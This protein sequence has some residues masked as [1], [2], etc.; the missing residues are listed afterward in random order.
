MSSSKPDNL[1]L[2]VGTIL[3][4]V[5][6]MSAGDA[7]IKSM[8]AA[9]TVG[10]WQLFAVRSVLVLPLLL[11]AGW[12]FGVRAS[13]LPKSILWVGLRAALLV[14]VWIAY[15]AALPNLPLSAAA[16]AL[17]TLP[18]FIVGFSALW[19]H[20]RV[21]PLQGV[22]AVLGFIGVALV[23]RPGTEAFSP[24][25][26]LPILAAM[27]FAGAMVLTRTRCQHEHPLAMVFGLHL[28]FILS[29]AIG[30]IVLATI[31][32]LAGDSF[33]S[34]TWHSLTWPEWKIMGLL[35][36]SILIASVGTAIA[37]QKAPTSIIGTFEFAYVGFAVLWGILFF[38]ELPDSLTLAGLA[39]IVLAGVLTVRK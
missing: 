12:Y 17:Y 11:A 29:G 4:T 9:S 3:F 13:L 36:L 18:L 32:S 27:L 5:F 2:A 37:Y 16:A 6:A 38:A 1:P 34:D 21:T 15:Y 23:L 39:L 20:D 30:L 22:A 28:A 26:L 19:T 10:L 35:A 33:L 24:Y 25:A 31:P 14:M 7:L 8:G